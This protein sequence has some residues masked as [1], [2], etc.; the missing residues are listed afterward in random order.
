MKFLYSNHKYNDDVWKQTNGKIKTICNDNTYSLEITSPKDIKSLAN[1]T[2]IFF[3]SPQ[4]QSKLT[5]QEK[6]VNL[7]ENETPRNN[8]L[9][10][11][12]S[13]DGCNFKPLL[14]KC[15]DIKW[16]IFGI[17]R[18]LENNVLLTAEEWTEF[19]T[20]AANIGNQLQ[21]AN[22]ELSIS[23]IKNTMNSVIKSVLYANEL[24]YIIS[25][26]I[27]C[28]GYLAAHGGNG[29]DGWENLPQNLRD[30]VQHNEKKNKTENKE[31]WWKSVI[32]DRVNVENELSNIDDNNENQERKNRIKDLLDEIDKGGGLSNIEI[33]NNA[34]SALKQI[35]KSTN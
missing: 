9:I 24:C 8:S 4:R 1:Y 18:K 35:L 25:L 20:W 10:F 28:Q 7:T 2:H 22:K 31:D 27:L 23:E 3:H 30:T 14:I 26:S 32:V 34:Y 19:F 12:M 6:A 16:Y 5:S 17:N 33:V 29:L 21:I 15:N 11:F 13:S